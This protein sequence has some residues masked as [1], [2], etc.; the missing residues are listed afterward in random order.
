MQNFAIEI[1]RV[2]PSFFKCSRLFNKFNKELK[3]NGDAVLTSPFSFILEYSLKDGILSSDDKDVLQDFVNLMSKEYGTCI[4]REEVYDS[5]EWNSILDWSLLNIGVC[6]LDDDSGWDGSPNA[7][8]ID[9]RAPGEIISIYYQFFSKRMLL[10]A[11]KLN[12]EDCL[13][14]GG[15]VVIPNLVDS[16]ILFKGDKTKHN[17]VKNLIKELI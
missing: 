9:N 13:K 1:G 17:I 12:K 8:F 15:G 11:Y 7:I 3:E 14:L 6:I 4:T 16:L 5:I 10:D 2:H